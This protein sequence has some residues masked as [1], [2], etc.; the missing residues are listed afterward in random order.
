MLVERVEVAEI[1][2]VTAKEVV[3]KTLDG[4]EVR[5]DR[6]KV[7]VVRPDDDPPAIYGAMNFVFTADETYGLTKY[8]RSKKEWEKRHAGP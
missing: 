3:V 2:S 1:L 7:P 4:R 6:R 8:E 5:L